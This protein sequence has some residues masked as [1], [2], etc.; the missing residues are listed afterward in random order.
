MSGD[1]HPYSS[2]I[3]RKKVYMLIGILS[4]VLTPLLSDLTNRLT[5]L[6]FAEPWIDISMSFALLFSSI[7]YVYDRVIWRRLP[8]GIIGIPSIAD[9]NGVYE[10]ELVSSYDK[11]TPVPVEIEVRQ[12]WTKIQIRMAT[13]KKQSQSYSYM[14]SYFDIGSGRSVL[15]YSYTNKPFNAI[16]DLDMQQHEG[17][18]SIEIDS[19]G[20]VSGTYFNARQRKGSILLEKVST[21]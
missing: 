11:S 15:S 5:F 12:T 13:A 16:A 4:A 20:N 3:G 2:N 8:I 19:D 1:I 21:D 6:N 7:F 14:A 18:V 9:M 10:G 17:T